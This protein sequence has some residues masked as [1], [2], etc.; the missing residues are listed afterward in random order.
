MAAHK[1]YAELWAKAGYRNMGSAWVTRPP[2]P[3]FS[4]LYH[5]TCA[6]NALSDI[7]H[8]RLKVARF[9]DVNDPFE[10]LS[11]NFRERRH[12]SIG[13]SF[14][15]MEISKTGFLSFSRNWTNPVLWSHYAHK[16]RGV[17]LG[18]NVSRPLTHPV[19]YEDK[20]ILEE[21]DRFN[22]DATKLSK[23]L[24]DRLRCTKS[25]H[26]RYEEEVRV[27]VRLENAVGERALHFQPF[28]DKLQLTE[29]ILGV[30]CECKLAEVRRLT[31]QL[32]PK[33]VVF[34][35]RLAFKH[36][37]IVPDERTIP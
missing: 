2:S 35:S 8:S 37:K 17:C 27:F 7:T 28:S 34:N 24:Q 23:A 36:Y 18:F 19:M 15:I 10:L 13:R 22:A 30:R 11:L 26:W 4:R 25:A 12:R 14:K 3:D 6:E 29:V 32:H 16:H 1:E 9:E 5:L 20:R 33:A 31:R 21:L